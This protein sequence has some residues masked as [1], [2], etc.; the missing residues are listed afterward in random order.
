M[1]TV[2][3]SLHQTLKGHQNPIYIVEEGLE[4]HTVFTAGNDKGVVEWDLLNGQFK[5]ILCAVPASVYA[6]HLLRETGLLMIGM[7]NGELWAVDVDK[8]ELVKK[9]KTDI[10]AIFAIKSVI[11]KNEL[12]TIGEEGVA[13]VWS[14]DKFELLYRFKVSDT[15][16]RVIEP[17]VKMN[18]VAFGDKNGYIHLYDLSDYKEIAKKKVHTLPVTA[19][20]ATDTYLYSGGRDAKLFQLAHKDLQE[21]NEITPHMFT[22]YGIIPHPI[23]PVFVTVSRDKS[24]KIWDRRSLSLL[25]NVSIERGYDSHYLSINSAVWVAD[26]LVTAGDDKLVKVWN[27]SIRT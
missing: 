1:Y 24:I 9:V 25:K 3:I 15:V 18:Q 5:R 17:N 8:Q 2:D 20:M 21:L 14:L 12:I 11:A 19:L 7:R 6:L 26:K 27:V 16:V 13:Y 22:V 10:G 4:P 23:A